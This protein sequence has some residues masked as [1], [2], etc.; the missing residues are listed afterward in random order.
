MLQV[1]DMQKKVWKDFEITNSDKYHD[2]CVSG[3]TV[4]LPD[5]F[6]NV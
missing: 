1:T 2:L 5:V 4:F 6:E 3:D